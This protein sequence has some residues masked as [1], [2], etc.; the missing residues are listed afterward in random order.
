MA[1]AFA[2]AMAG[3]AS[4]A[5]VLQQC[6][7]EKVEYEGSTFQAPIDFFW[8]G[9][10]S[11]KANELTG[12]GF[13]VSTA[14]SACSGTQGSKAKPEVYYNQENTFDRGS[15]SCLKTWGNGVKTF[16]ENKS[17]EVYPRL[18][19]FPFCATDE[20][21]SKGVK[22]EFEKYAEPGGEAGN[23]ESI[24]SIPVL[25]GAVAIIVHLPAGC[26]ATSEFKIGKTKHSYGRLSL[27]QKE[28]SNIYTGKVK[29]WAA[30]LSSQAKADGKNKIKCASKTALDKTIRPVVRRDKSGTTHIFKAFLLQVNGE[31]FPMEE[32]HEVAGE[33][34][35]AESAQLNAGV[36]RTWE[37]VS[38]GCENQRWPEAAK[39]L[40]PPVETGNPGVIKEVENT[41]SS[42]GYADLAV[43]QELKDF[44][45]P[46]GGE[47]KTEFW[48]LVQNSAVTGKTETF[49]EPSTVAGDK[50]TEGNSNCEQTV[51]VAKAGEKF[52][53][54]STRYDWSKVKAEKISKTYPICG[55]T[56]VLAAR[57][58]Y[59]YL[60]K[61][62][63][64]ATEA[65]KVATTVH[66]FLTY[67][68]EIGVVE[69][70][71]HDYA[72]LPKAVATEALTGAEEIG[73]KEA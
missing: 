47:G 25:Q 61:Y 29:T 4:A 33:K 55:L 56:Y 64:D 60:E 67:V 26:K 35:C 32:F 37:E 14:P 65:Q 49:A 72:S 39:V 68:T 30:L 8:T 48:A 51:Y 24:E 18:K 52:P 44:N 45:A 38:E 71:D 16:G 53:P 50:E 73:S 12:T 69:A 21:P 54:S 7:G 13:N 5:D 28:I 11:D 59:Y 70:N 22:E 6:A 34:P 10:N 43:A 41:E 19:T 15:G 1:A 20:A 58:Y 36:D 17:G 62:G 27:D 63:L 23:G 2:L 9:K 3:T 57:Q 42:I 31:E 46:T 40:R 66:D